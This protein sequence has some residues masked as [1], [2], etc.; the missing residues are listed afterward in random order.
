MV[1][2]LLL[3]VSKLTYDVDLNVESDVGVTSREKME[4]SETP[5]IAGI[6]LHRLKKQTLTWRNLKT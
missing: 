5:C 1:D 6:I 4:L 3:M 2:I